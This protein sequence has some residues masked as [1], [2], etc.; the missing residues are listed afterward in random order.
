M[1][2]GGADIVDPGLDEVERAALCMALDDEGVAAASRLPCGPTRAAVALPGLGVRLGVF[3]GPSGRA[4]G[5]AR[6][7]ETRFEVRAIG[8]VE[9]TLTDLASAPKQGDEGAPDAWL[10]FDPAVAEALQG[11]RAGDDALLLTWLD[12]GRRDE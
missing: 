10:V 11:V 4:Q 12:R 7:D 5:R 2:A 3:Q 9:S 8:R 1:F 6:M